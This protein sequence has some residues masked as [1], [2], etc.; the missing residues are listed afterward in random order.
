[1]DSYII[2]QML[3]Y[4][5]LHGLQ[6]AQS[7]QAVLDERGEGKTLEAS[8][9]ASSRQCDYN[10]SADSVSRCDYRGYAVML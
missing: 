10:G 5:G 7:C 2:A 6:H 1:M 8:R 4:I 9:S 3:V